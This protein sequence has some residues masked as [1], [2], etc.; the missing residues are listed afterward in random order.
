M[1]G[2]DQPKITTFVSYCHADSKLVDDLLQRLRLRMNVAK[3]YE[4]ESW[5]D[6][7][8]LAGDSWKDE[9]DD[10][11]DRADLGL[12]FVSFPFLNS[13]FIVR[14]ELPRFLERGDGKRPI[15]I[16]LSEVPFDGSVKLFGLEERQFFLGKDGR[17]AGG[18]YYDELAGGE[19]NRF[20]DQLFREILQI[21]DK[22]FCDKCCGDRRDSHG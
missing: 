12:L 4:F 16:G 21:C 8:I 11:L 22:Y 3:R 10:A 7:K 6:R 9:I 17:G 14:Q 13:D 5:D 1:S 19:R 20:V 18:R 2:T 15:P